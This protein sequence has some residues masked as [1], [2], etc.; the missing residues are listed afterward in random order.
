MRAVVQRVSEAA[1]DVDG[2]EISRI[3][4]GLLV[5]LG[6][7]TADGPAEADWMIDKL[8]ALRA[9]ERATGQFDA[10]VIDVGGAVLVVSQFTLYADTRKGRR[11]SFSH[12]AAAD[13]AEPLYL[14]VVRGIAERGIPVGTGRFGAHMVVRAANNGPVTLIVDTPASAA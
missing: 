12:A 3:G 1:V 6:I 2:A 8:L 13:Q 4:R 5:Y 11:P 9:F 14:R 7:G 10:S